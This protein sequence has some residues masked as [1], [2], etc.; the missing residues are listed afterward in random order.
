MSVD[1]APFH[2]DFHA[3]RTFMSK[4]Y[5]TCIAGY[6]KPCR[7]EA[8]ALDTALAWIEESRRVWS[9]RMDRLETHLARLQEREGK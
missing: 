2:T 9:D 4:Q 1:F 8:D 5:C 3:G 6:I 7:L